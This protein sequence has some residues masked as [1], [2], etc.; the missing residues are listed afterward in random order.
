MPDKREKS[1]AR[2]E[3]WSEQHLQQ[4][5]QLHFAIAKTGEKKQNKRPTERSRHSTKERG[6]LAGSV[7]V[8]ENRLSMPKPMNVNDNKVR[9]LHR[10]KVTPKIAGN[11]VFFNI[12]MNVCHF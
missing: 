11:F 7:R 12:I 3:N 4:L 8:R 1:V 2:K 10:E 9:L 5:Q 6:S